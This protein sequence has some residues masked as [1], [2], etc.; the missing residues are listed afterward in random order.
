MSIRWIRAIRSQ[1]NRH[2]T[3]STKRT[4]IWSFCIICSTRIIP[5]MTSLKSTMTT[6]LL[7]LPSLVVFRSSNNSVKTYRWR[8]TS[9]YF[10][11]HT[12]QGDESLIDRGDSFVWTTKDILMDDLRTHTCFRELFFVVEFSE[13]HSKYRKRPRW[14]LLTPLSGFLVVFHLHIIYLIVIDLFSCQDV[15]P[16][17]EFL[18]N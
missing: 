6:L 7:L 12:T 2:L 14:G 9:Y 18:T 3:P 8:F 16:N 4:L 11:T 15:S 1:R 17:G 10:F 13:W 5:S